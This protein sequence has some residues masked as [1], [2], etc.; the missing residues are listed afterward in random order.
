MKLNLQN[1]CQPDFRGT[2]VLPSEMLSG[3]RSPARLNNSRT[4]GC[5]AKLKLM[6]IFIGLAGTQAS[7]AQDLLPKP[8]GPY[9]VGRTVLR[10]QDPSRLEDVTVDNP[11]DKRR[12]SVLLWY[13]ADNTQRSPRAPFVSK[14]ADFVKI[15]HAQKPNVPL[16]VIQQAVSQLRPWATDK[17][18]FAGNVARAP[19][20]LMSHGLGSMPEEYESLAEELASF[21]YVV[22]GVN[23]TYGSTVN[24]YLPGFPTFALD[25]G[26]DTK[27]HLIAATSGKYVRDWSYD[28]RL[29]LTLL[30]GMDKQP[31]SL[32][33]G[34]LDTQRVAAIGHSL[35]GAASIVASYL[36][37]R[38][39]CAANLD[40][41][42][43][44][45]GVDEAPTK[46]VM[47]FHHDMAEHDL[48]AV[49]PFVPTA[50][51]LARLNATRSE[52]DLFRYFSLRQFAAEGK[53]ASAGGVALKLAN[54]D[55]G[56][57]SDFTLIDWV[58][59]NGTGTIDPQRAHFVINTYVKAF[60]DEK[61]RD[62]PSVLL[63]ETSADFP[64]VSLIQPI[65]D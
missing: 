46:P 18:P 50:K 14:A 43:W 51:L 38:I 62:T 45:I 9:A 30:E 56:D 25:D 58:N 21:G 48:A 52:Y 34:K 60:L 54:S 8:Q 40:G 32:L 3:N 55:H 29:T 64:E 20:V 63:R 23:H 4:T 13:P 11:T 2:N 26:P 65:A 57:F 12:L 47:F 37:E 53:V 15:F 44:E 31:D 5:I 27:L 10:L 6:V 16:P 59:K 22:A 42:L 61:L 39:D 17:P 24:M 7:L 35:G 19:I 33:F 41:S 36:D 49:Y 28:L 1:F